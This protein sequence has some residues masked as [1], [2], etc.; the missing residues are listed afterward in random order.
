MFNR[1]NRRAMF[2]VGHLIISKILIVT[3]DASFIA[4]SSR[5]K[6]GVLSIRYRKLPVLTVLHPTGYFLSV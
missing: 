6:S 1:E 5:R 3:K 4:Y 2:L